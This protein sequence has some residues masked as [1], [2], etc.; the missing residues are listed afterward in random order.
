MS[1]GVHSASERAGSRNLSNFPHRGY[2]CQLAP[3]YTD[4]CVPVAEAHQATMFHPSGRNPAFLHHSYPCTFI[5][6]AQ[7]L[8]PFFRRGPPVLSRA[9]FLRKG[10]GVSAFGFFKGLRGASAAGVSSAPLSSSALFVV[11]SGRSPEPDCSSE[12][13]SSAGTSARGTTCSSPFTISSI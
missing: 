4:D 11:S 1:L 12:G 5:S 2:Q 9:P 3:G 6:T 13:T 8:S 7:S 10:R